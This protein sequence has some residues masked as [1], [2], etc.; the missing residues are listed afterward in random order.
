MPN[1]L[2]NT[3]TLHKYYFF[4][5]VMS[6]F[7]KFLINFC[8]FPFKCMYVCMDGCNG[9]LGSICRLVSQRSNSK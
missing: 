5:L 6:S 9:G 7:T 2:E 8:H 4:N 3:F 1:M